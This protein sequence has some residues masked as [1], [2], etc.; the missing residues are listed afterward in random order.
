MRVISKA[1][2]RGFWEQPRF[3]DSEQPLKTWFNVTSKARW[4]SFA[5]VKADYG[6]NVD[7]AHGKYVFDIKGNT[8]RLVCVIDFVQHGVLVLW[9]GT[10]LDYDRLCA[11]DGARLKQL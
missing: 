4:T 8:Y 10:H 5:D 3:A 7:L 1:K 2:L 6:V 11:R 9:V